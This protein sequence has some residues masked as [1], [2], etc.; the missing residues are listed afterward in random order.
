MSV[1]VVEKLIKNKEKRI[2]Q[3]N[4]FFLFRMFKRKEKKFPALVSTLKNMNENYE[5][6]T[7]YQS[8]FIKQ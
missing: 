6:Y 7:L 2:D 3:R 1:N 8:K 4:V 5:N